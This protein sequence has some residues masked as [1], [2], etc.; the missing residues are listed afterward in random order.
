MAKTFGFE[1]TTDEVLEGVDLSGKR[2]LVT[3]VSAGLGVETARALVAHGATVV[4][5]ARDLTKARQALA[6][7]MPQS[8]SKVD[9]VE[10]DLASLKSVR[11]GAS[12]LLARAKPFDTIIANAGVMACPQGK[13]QDG[14]ET[15]FGTNHLGHFVLVNRLVPLLKPGARIVSLSSAGHQI[16]DVDLEDPN[17]E[18]TPYQAFAAYGRSKTANIL[19]AVAL[20]S[21]LKGRGIR[22]T[23]LHPGGI[24]TE[25]G[26]HLTPELL[27]QMRAR[28][29]KTGQAEYRF[30]TVPQGAATTVWA[31]FVA[32]SDEVGG[33]YCEDCHVC[34]VNDDTTSRIGVRSYALDLNRANAL[35]RKSEEMVGERFSL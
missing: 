32:S 14:F 9:L 23:A 11:N 18:R 10:A 19:Y 33:R 4:G 8:A 3:G 27:D 7:A 28:F 1:S 5:T 21:R 35:W 16:S 25:L 34:E 12:D 20:D 2:V 17:F 13:T 30:K 29:A 6:Q 15:Q 26:R 24:Q 31:G 22:A